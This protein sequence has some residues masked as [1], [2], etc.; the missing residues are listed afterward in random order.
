M[1]EAEDRAHAEAADY[2]RKRAEKMQAE[3]LLLQEQR[4][5]ATAWDGVP[6]IALFLIMLGLVITLA[7]IE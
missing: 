7:S 6:Y 3:N 2:W 4:R 5:P 1:S